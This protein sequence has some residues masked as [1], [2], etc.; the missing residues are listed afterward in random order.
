MV[1]V[2]FVTAHSL[3]LY[4]SFLEDRGN[5]GNDWSGE[6]AKSALAVGV[7]PVL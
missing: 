1:T 6:A 5:V 4:C 3:P 7:A 2:G